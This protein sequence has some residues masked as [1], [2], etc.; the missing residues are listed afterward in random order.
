MMKT[1]TKLSLLLVSSVLLVMLMT[2][3][4]TQA[5]MFLSSPVSPVSPFRS[6]YW[7]MI[8]GEPESTPEGEETP[9]SMAT[10]PLLIVNNVP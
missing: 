4:T 6:L 2:Q 8:W 9:E 5:S 3:V 7:P 10:L 1:H